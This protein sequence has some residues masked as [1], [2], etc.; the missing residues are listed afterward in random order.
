MVLVALAGLAVVIAAGMV[1]VLPP[2]ESLPPPQWPGV[3]PENFG[4]IKIGMSRRDVAAL[5][6]GPPGNYSTVPVKVRRTGS[7]QGM[8]DDRWIGDR[9]AIDVWFCATGGSWGDDRVHRQA[10]E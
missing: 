7:K 4:R 6:G 3:T 8:S 5:L 2:S 10:A 1:L 9:A